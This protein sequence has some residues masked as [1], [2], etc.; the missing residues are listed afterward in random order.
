MVVAQLFTLLFGHAC[1]Q[2]D[3]SKSILIVNENVLKI[4]V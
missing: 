3:S 4:N 2:V 1:N